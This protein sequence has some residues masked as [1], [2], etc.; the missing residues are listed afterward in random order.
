MSERS[1]C[2]DKVL[3]ERQEICDR[4]DLTLNGKPARLFGAA[5]RFP[6]IVDNETGLSCEFSWVAVYNIIENHNGA[7]RS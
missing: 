4:R 2:S 3:A 5:L 1:Y 6:Q 7:F